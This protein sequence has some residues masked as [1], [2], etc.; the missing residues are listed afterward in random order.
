MISYED[1]NRVELFNETNIDWSAS[2]E[3]SSINS[4]PSAPSSNEYIPLDFEYKSPHSEE[5]EYSQFLQYSISADSDS[6]DWE[7]SPTSQKHNDFEDLT[8]LNNDYPSPSASSSSHSESNDTPSPSPPM[9]PRRGPGH[10]SKAS[11]AAIGKRP[12]GRSLV[13]I[14]RQVHNNSA[15]RSRA[16]F[17]TILEELWELIPSTEKMQAISKA[18]PARQLCRAEKMEI[19]ISYLK[20]LQRLR[21]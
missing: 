8:S 19:A 10:P 17:N 2:F 21:K 15:M 13:T 18:D 12:T 4:V 1:L 7:L 9:V 3:P 5:I 11:L 6:T 16:K 14:R 20:K